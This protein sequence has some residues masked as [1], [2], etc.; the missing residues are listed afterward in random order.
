MR[1][2]HH[3]YCTS[4]TLDWLMARVAIHHHTFERSVSILHH[5]MIR[6]CFDRIFCQQVL[7]ESHRQ[8]FGHVSG[9]VGDKHGLHLRIEAW[10][11]GSAPGSSVGKSEYTSFA[12]I[13][14]LSDTVPLGPTTKI[15]QGSVQFKES[16]DFITLSNEDFFEL[17]Y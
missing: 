8:L 12:P 17:A 14:I 15:F 6:R 2:L 3:R 13:E 16:V 4:S 1:L 10:I 11:S 7:T 9:V 5:H